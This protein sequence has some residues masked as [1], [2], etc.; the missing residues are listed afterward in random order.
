MGQKR[1]S[2]RWGLIKQSK[3]K[4]D[5]RD[6]INTHQVSCIFSRYLNVQ[7]FSAQWFEWSVVYSV[8]TVEKHYFPVPQPVASLD[9]FCSFIHL[10]ASNILC[11]IY[12]YSD[13]HRFKFFVLGM[14]LFNCSALFQ[15]VFWSSD[16]TWQNIMMKIVAVKYNDKNNAF[17]RA[18]GNCFSGVVKNFYLP[19]G[20]ETL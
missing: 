4:N 20:W 10:F 12:F 11:S 8:V 13:I 17:Q 19:N 1:L 15:V 14:L 7:V 16:M 5:M 3:T 6:I 18:R 9:F 2:W